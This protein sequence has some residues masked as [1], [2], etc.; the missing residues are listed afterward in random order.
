MS[1]LTIRPAENR[2]YDILVTELKENGGRVELTD[3]YEKPDGY[4]SEKYGR[5]MDDS[6]SCIRKAAQKGIKVGSVRRPNN[7]VLE[8]VSR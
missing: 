2:W 7:G 8:L 6:G 1:D 5:T 3:L 4:Y